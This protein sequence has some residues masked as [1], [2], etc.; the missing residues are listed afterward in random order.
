MQASAGPAG[1][2]RQPSL[3]QKLWSAL[4]EPVSRIADWLPPPPAH[5]KALKV[6]WPRA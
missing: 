6:G 3:S 4:S 2:G 5:V 1:L